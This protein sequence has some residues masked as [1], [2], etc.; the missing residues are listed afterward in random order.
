[1]ESNIS[2]ELTAKSLPNNKNGSLKLRLTVGVLGI[3][4]LCLLTLGLLVLQTI[5]QTVHTSFENE[6]KS[7]VA[8]VN[9]SIGTKETIDSS[10]SQIEKTFYRLLENNK[11]IAKVTLYSPVDGKYIRT[12]TTDPAKKGKEADPHDIEPLVTNKPL[13]I[14][15]AEKQQVEILAPVYIEGSDKPYATIGVYFYSQKRDELLKQTII[16]LLSVTVIC[17]IF[18]AVFIYL[19]FNNMVFTRIKRLS[20]AF[21]YIFNSNYSHRISVNVKAKDEIEKL[22]QEFNR[23]ADMLESRHVSSITDPITGLYNQFYFNTQIDQEI[24]RSNNENEFALLFIDVD[25]F[26]RVNDQLGHLEGDRILE[27][28]G[29]LIKEQLRDQDLVARYGGEEF[30]VL[31]PDCK[32]ETALKVAERIRSSI[33]SYPVAK[34]LLPV[35]VSIGVSTYPQNG[36]DKKG[37]IYSAD[38]AMYVS[39]AQGRNRVT[40]S[41]LGIS[42]KDSKEQNRPEESF[43]SQDVKEMIFAFAEAMDAKDSYT[44]KHSETVSRYS[45]SIAA[46]LGLTELEIK[47]ITIAGLLHDVGKIG[48][49][50]SIL[51]KPAKLTDEEFE[52][53][54]Q[55]PTLGKNILEHISSI[56]DI[57][58]YVEFH[59]ERYDGKGYPDG[60]KGEQ[61]PLGAR[62]V[63]VADAFHAMTSSRPYRQTPLTLEQAIKELKEHSGTQFDPIVVD[64]FVSMVEEW[65]KNNNGDIIF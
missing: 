39:K 54:K 48:V 21:N 8:S 7:I 51:N 37:L 22:G 11:D 15:K 18:I 26:K 30:V 27:S 16:H 65:K 24:K 12:A 47:R 46:G 44:Q 23:M 50:D 53:I 38:T 59:Q 63:A 33:A 40:L 58:E 19:L 55:H 61:I 4:F 35:T 14:E 41:S 49:P 1:M 57:L 9:A 31:I 64:V 45:G 32:P 42:E 3:L 52:I 6:A 25:H 60:L 62:I 56:K 5:K 13:F 36:K 34:G 2:K 43:D 20:S 17:F 29:K 10:P 28:I